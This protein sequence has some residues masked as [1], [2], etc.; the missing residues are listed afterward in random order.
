MANPNPRSPWHSGRPGREKLHRILLSGAVILSFAASTAAEAA[1]AFSCNFGQDPS[2]PDSC[3]TGVAYDVSGLSS[4]TTNTL[5]NLSKLPTAGSGTI[6]FAWV[7]INPSP[8]YNGDFWRVNVAFD[9]V[10]LQPGH[11]VGVVEYSLQLNPDFADPNGMT[12]WRFRDEQL[13]FTNVNPASVV[14]QVYGDAAFTNLLSTLTVP[15]SPTSF[16]NGS[17]GRSQ[18][19]VRNTYAAIAEGDE[20][21]TISNFQNSFRQQQPLLRGTLRQEPQPSAVP[22][23]LPL[24]GA[25]VALGFSRR[26]RRR[27]RGH[28]PVAA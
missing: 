11:G 13:A 21:G 2:S 4:P 23:P 7:P 5:L 14:E 3:E 1:K 18:I 9:P 22:G 24:F 28:G 25:S 15:T 6:S 27:L 12:G 10:P 17:A 26:L 8:G 16:R 19:W 20:V